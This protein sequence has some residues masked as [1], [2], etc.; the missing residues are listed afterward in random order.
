MTVARK[1]RVLSNN[2]DTE[3]TMSDWCGSIMEKR[4]ISTYRR[5]K[6]SGILK[7]IQHKNN[8]LQRD[9][10]LNGNAFF[11]V[12]GQSIFSRYTHNEA[13]YWMS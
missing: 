3:R 7:V 10:V 11:I 5:W 4:V 9:L 1:I 8:L 13:I 6:G 2:R 12:E